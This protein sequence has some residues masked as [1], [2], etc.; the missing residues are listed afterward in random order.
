MKFNRNKVKPGDQLLAGP[1]SVPVI[2]KGMGPCGEV[3]IT[4]RGPLDGFQRDA[5]CRQR[6]VS[7]PDDL[8]LST[9]GLA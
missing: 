9:E 8:N 7:I 5:I 4:Y 3:V 2:F 1:K 6:D